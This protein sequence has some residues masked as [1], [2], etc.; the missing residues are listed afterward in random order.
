M[1][2]Q[3]FKMLWL[4]TGSEVGTRLL[5][6]ANDTLFMI[7]SKL[8]KDQTIRTFQLFLFTFWFIN[9]YEVSGARN[10]FILI[11]HSELDKISIPSTIPH[12]TSIPTQSSSNRKT[13]LKSCLQ[14]RTRKIQMN[15]KK[16]IFF[17]SAPFSSFIIRNNFSSFCNIL[18]TF[19]H[20]SFL[21]FIQHSVTSIHAHESNLL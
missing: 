15:K 19:I 20:L 18:A 9:T 13:L 6:S 8:I 16:R 21:T 11:L 17:K 7:F 5:F 14:E 2:D 1:L 10:L 3:R 4:C 12:F